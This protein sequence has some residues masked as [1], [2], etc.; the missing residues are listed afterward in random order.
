[1]GSLT[2][3]LLVHNLTDTTFFGSIN[4]SFWSLAVECQ[5]ISVGVFACLSDFGRPR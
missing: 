3:E 1:M 2:D 4:G 5:Y